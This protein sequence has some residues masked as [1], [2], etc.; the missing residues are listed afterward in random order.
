LYSSDFIMDKFGCRWGL[1]PTV[2]SDI[3]RDGTSCDMSLVL[4]YVCLRCGDG[5]CKNPENK[6]NCPADCK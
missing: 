4:F 6:C 5:I 3:L 1:R 2:G